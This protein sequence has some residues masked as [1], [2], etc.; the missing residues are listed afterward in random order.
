MEFPIGEPTEFGHIILPDK[1]GF[2]PMYVFVFFLYF[3]VL[4]LS[5]DYV[6]QIQTHVQA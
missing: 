5:N 4:R 1:T 6:Q 2:G 3:I